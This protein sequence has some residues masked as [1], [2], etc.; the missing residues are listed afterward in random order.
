[1]EDQATDRALRIG[2]TKTVQ[3]FKIITKVLLKRYLS[4]KRR[5]DTNNVI[6][7]GENLLT[8]LKEEEIR[9]LFQL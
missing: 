7:P 5:R 8:K 6:Q 2:Q 4:F 3:V 9:E 1:M